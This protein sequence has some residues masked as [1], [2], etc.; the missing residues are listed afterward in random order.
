M[1]IL[2]PPFCSTI[3]ATVRKFFNVILVVKFLVKNI[4]SFIKINT[5]HLFTNA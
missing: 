4:F 3:Y 5:I 1:P 2:L